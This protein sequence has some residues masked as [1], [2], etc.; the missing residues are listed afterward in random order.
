MP[1][2]TVS[3]SAYAGL[4]GI[5][6][7]APDADAARWEEP[8]PPYT[9]YASRAAL[10]PYVGSSQPP[11]RAGTTGPIVAL[12]AEAVLTYPHIPASLTLRRTGQANVYTLG[13]SAMQHPRF[14]VSVGPVGRHTADGH[15]TLKLRPAHNPTAPALASATVDMRGVARPGTGPGLV[16]LRLP[17]EEAEVVVE[18]RQR[19][20]WHFRLAVLGSRPGLRNDVDEVFAWQA[21]GRG[22]PAIAR[23][24]PPWWRAWG[25]FGFQLVRMGQEPEVVAACSETKGFCSRLRT[26]RVGRGAAAAWGKRWALVVL[27]GSLGVTMAHRWDLAYAAELARRCEAGLGWGTCSSC[28]NAR[29]CACWFQ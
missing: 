21:G 28:G 25:W 4:L 29:T 17:G 20:Q 7:T 14:L 27:M 10:P 1:A 12:S 22:E 5:P 18:R 19:G 16:R 2:T 15:V 9:K 23:L 6:D 13:A 8:P 11:S 3:G 24:G 26:E